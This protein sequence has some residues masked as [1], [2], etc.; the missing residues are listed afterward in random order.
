MRVSEALSEAPS[1]GVGQPVSSNFLA[2]IAGRLSSIG[3][4]IL[5]FGQ[6]DTRFREVIEALPAAIYT[7]DKDGRITFY[8]EAAE[9]MWGRKPTLGDDQWCG[10]WKLYWPDGTMLPHDECPMAIA[11]KTGKP[12][13]GVEAVAERPDG[14]RVPFAPYPT[15]IFD[16]SGELA[17]AVNMLVDL[18][19]RKLAEENAQRLA[20]IVTSSDDAIISKDLNGIIKSWNR[21]A[22]RLFGYNSEEAIG[23]PVTLLIPPERLDEEPSIL[24]RLRRGERIDHY[25]TV[26]RRK[27]GSL[28]DIS[29]TVSPIVSADGRII[30][31]S[32]IARDITERK[33]AQE[34][35]KVLLAEIMHRV[36]NTLATVQAIASQTLRRAPADE[37]GAFT[38]RLHALSKAHDLLTSDKWDRAPL[39]AVVGAAVEPFEKERFTLEGPESWFNASMSLQV[40]LALH[41]L[42]TN[43]A[44][45][46]ALHNRSGQVH[47]TWE[48]LDVG[49]L[50]LCWR[51]TGG[52]TVRPPE[53][54]G[55]GSILIEHTFEEVH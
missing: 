23:R 39:R 34:Q 53:H 48:L 27:D 31:A 6:D 24:E 22:E 45:Y 18:T 32:K 30:G 33:R 41:E 28:V 19:H 12:V 15:P 54:K 26:R 14:T 50:K 51:E 36:K 8:N 20:A 42:A 1:S 35:Q 2:S 38:A 5:A 52:P 7:T 55:F 4:A 3:Q 25:E 9:L 40:T 17:G 44:K 43:A 46:G 37:Q 47:L 11:L 49:R 13:R 29:L 10:S 21:G 16:A